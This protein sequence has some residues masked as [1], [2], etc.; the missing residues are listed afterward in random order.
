MADHDFDAVRRRGV[1]YWGLIL[2]IVGVFALLVNLNLIPALNWNYFWPLLLIVLGLAIIFN[3]Y[4][5]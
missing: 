3:H 4:K 1:P 5:K 2:I